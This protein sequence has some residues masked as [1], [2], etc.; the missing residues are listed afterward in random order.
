MV[1]KK[2][3]IL[4]CVFLLTSCFRYFHIKQNESG[5]PIVDEK[6]YTLNKRKTE[7]NLK[8]IDTTSY[9]IEVTD[10]LY[11]RKS[12]P[13]ILKF[14]NDGTFEIKSKK[15]FKQFYKNRIKQ[16]VFYGGRFILSN[17]ELKIERFYPSKGG[18]S[19][20][21]IKKIALVQ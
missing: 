17:N 3:I 15:Y 18:K 5:E 9:Y 12:N 14:H 6:L 10:F 2:M 4:I 16:S 13:S 8:I 1:V 20:Y 21:Y 11:S 19:N 7:D